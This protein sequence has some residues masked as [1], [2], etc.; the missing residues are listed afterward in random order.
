MGDGG[1]GRAGGVASER[2]RPRPVGAT[3]GRP[4]PDRPAPVS[5]GGADPNPYNCASAA[6]ST[7][8]TSP[9]WT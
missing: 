8:P 7:D 2:F 5:E 3:G 9:G 4:F 1:W 6:P